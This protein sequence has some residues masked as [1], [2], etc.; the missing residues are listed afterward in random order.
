MKNVV[1]LFIATLV[2]FSCSSDKDDEMEKAAEG[3]S[4]VGVWEFKELDVTGATGNIDWAEDVLTKL[5][6]DDCD[7][8]T[9][10]FK[11]NKT[12]EASVRDFTTTGVDVNPA[13]GGL[14][15]ECPEIVEVATTIW[16]LDG[17]TLTFINDN[18]EEEMIKIE[19]TADTL[20]IPGE[21]IN[22]ANLA[23]VKAI[24]KRK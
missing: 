10:D 22:E 6:A 11:E 3:T 8:V 24:F 4:V 21:Y 7:V 12:V 5:V 23:G 13:G 9:F 20:T 15:I 18:L 14:L 17:S 2:S 16:S 19:L 1:L